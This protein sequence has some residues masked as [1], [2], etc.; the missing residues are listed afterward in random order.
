LGT[1]VP[2]SLENVGDTDLSMISV[3]AKTYLDPLPFDRFI[4]MKSL[5][6]DWVIFI[7]NPLPFDK[8]TNK[9]IKSGIAYSILRYLRWCCLYSTDHPRHEWEEA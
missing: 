5:G 1:L 2:H 3:E 7:T 4:N 8:I 6:S 9:S